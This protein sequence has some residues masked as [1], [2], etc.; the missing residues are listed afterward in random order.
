MPKKCW[1]SGLNEWIYIRIQRFDDQKLEK[2]QLKIC[3]K[4]SFGWKIAI[5]SWSDATYYILT[6][7]HYMKHVGCKD[8]HF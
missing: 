4:I 8:T 2:I 7:V 6:V 1:G 3:L 5:E